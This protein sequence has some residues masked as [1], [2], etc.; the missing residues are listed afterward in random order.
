MKTS[1]HYHLFYLLLILLLP[2]SS[3]LSADKPALMLAKVFQESAE[4]TEYWISEKLDGVRGR[5][6]G[7]QLITRGGILLSAPGWFIKDFPKIPLDGELW[8]GRGEYQQTVSITKRKKPHSGWRKVKF[9]VFDLPKHK[10]NFSQ[11]VAVM[12]N[13]EKQTQS[14]Y[15][16]FIRQFQL[17]SNAALMHQLNTITEQGG[18]G[19]M[20]HNKSGIYHSGRSKD[21]L[22][23]K[24]FTDADAV[25]IGYRP[26]KGK[27]KGKMGAIQVK[28]DTGKLFY[29][30]SGFSLNERINP[31]KIGSTISFR[32]QGVTLS[33]IPR[34]AV[35]IRVRNEP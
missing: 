32:H 9:M 24:V 13:M 34:F 22:K 12:R 20:L 15:L 21:L 8:V 33:G 10:G 2:L 30:G 3:A 5:W 27:F 7:Q 18:E 11:R 19:L 6:D 35:F 14:P 31:P 23:L 4:V 1:N 17:N 26:G 28:T 25:V 16:H 29:I